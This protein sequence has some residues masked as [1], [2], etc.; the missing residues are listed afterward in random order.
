VTATDN[1]QAGHYDG[2][3]D[4]Y[5]R[6]YYDSY[7][8]QYREQFILAPLLE[9]V[10]LRGKRV[11]DLASGSGETS[12]FLSARYPGVQCEGFDVSPEACRRYRQRTQRPATE[13]DLTRGGYAGDPFDAAIIMG[14]LHHCAAGL[15]VALRTVADMVRPGGLFLFFEPNREYALEAARRVWY[16]FDRYFDAGSERA[17]AHGE[18]TAAAAGAF[19]CRRLRYFGGPAFFLV[20]NSLVF[21]L[22]AGTK[23]A[24]APSLLRAE[25][26]Y[27]RLPSRWLF[28]S[29]LAQWV[30][31]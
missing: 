8:L 13:L 20:Y 12:R 18:L 6:H 24:V 21:R 11:A 5:D 2:I 23:S 7:S 27:N 15:D 25:R 4:A 31:V 29:F 30:R 1:P 19:E 17:L 28:A 16:R 26:L 9:G 10:D 3:L 22:S 14:G